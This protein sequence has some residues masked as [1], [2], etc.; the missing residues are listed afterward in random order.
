M[1]RRIRARKQQLISDEDEEPLPL[2]VKIEEDLN[3]S[4]GLQDEDDSRYSEPAPPKKKENP[5]SELNVALLVVSFE[6]L[7]ERSW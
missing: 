5:K 4:W 1:S 2:K 3:S 6:R 7:T